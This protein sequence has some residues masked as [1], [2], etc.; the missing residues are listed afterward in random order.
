VLLAAQADSEWFAWTPAFLLICAGVL[1]AAAPG[2]T[3]PAGTLALVTVTGALIAT[4]TTQIRIHGADHPDA[5]FMLLTQRDWICAATGWVCALVVLRSATPRPAFAVAILTGAAASAVVGVT[6]YVRDLVTGRSGHSLHNLVEFVR[7]P[8]WLT[9]VLLVIT[10]AAAGDLVRWRAATPAGVRIPATAGVAVIGL[11]IATGVTAPLTVARGDWSRFTAAI[12]AEQIRNRPADP[13]TLPP[14]P[15]V[16]YPPGTADP[17]RALTPAAITTALASVRHALPS[18]WKPGQNS[19]N[20]PQKGVRP[21]SCASKLDADTVVEN[22]Q[23]HVAAKRTTLE[24]PD[25]AMPPLGASLITSVTSFASPADAFAYVNDAREEA[26][27]C[28]QWTAPAPGADGGRAEFTMRADGGTGTSYP[29]FRV[30]L[31]EGWHINGAPGLVIGSQSWVVIGHNVI[32][33]DTVYSY[34]GRATVPA[35]RLRTVRGLTDTAVTAIVASL[36]HD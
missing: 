1:F 4:I 27:A 33:V 2:R 31:T 21:A 7:I 8:T 35:N 17:G 15:V 29:G 28:A 6:Q 22:A 12:T 9:F 30:L 11:A 14:N 18:Q 16:S 3:L 23:V 26:V 10:F 19:P 24:L 34:L 5:I 36:G 25:S 20:T 32:S 13:A